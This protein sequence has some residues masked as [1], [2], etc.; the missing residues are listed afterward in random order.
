MAR[1]LRLNEVHGTIKNVQNST[2]IRLSGLT[3]G[4]TSSYLLAY[5][6][7]WTIQPALTTNDE[8]IIIDMVSSVAKDIN[9]EVKFIEI[10]HKNLTIVL[11]APP[12]LSVSV[13]VK[14]LKGTTARKLT[15]HELLKVGVNKS[16]WDKGYVA[17]SIKI[18]QGQVF[19]T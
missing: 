4:R 12:S 16:L 11:C 17:E 6:L 14:K 5:K 3:H 18:K 15:S 10:K 9:T 13:I 1:L 8:N 2:D 7:S 19:Y